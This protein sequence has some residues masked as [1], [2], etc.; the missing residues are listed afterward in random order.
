MQGT[1]GTAEG[2]WGRKG[3]G[4][5]RDRGGPLGPQGKQGTL[6][7]RHSPPGPKESRVHYGA[8]TAPQDPKE[9]GYIMVQAQGPRDHYELSV[10]QGTQ[11]PR[12]D[13]GDAFPEGSPECGEG[14]W[15][16]KGGG[17]PGMRAGPL[18]PHYGQG[19]LE[20]RQ[21]G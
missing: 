9:A 11:N 5:P 17:A 1:L 8:S 21:G 6:W 2:R 12:R 16:R 13:L 19:P 15:G 20:C 14:G 7:C 18:W 3:A 10:R 4:D